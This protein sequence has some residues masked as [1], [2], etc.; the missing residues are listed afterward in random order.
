MIIVDAG[1]PRKEIIG[2][3]SELEVLTAEH[4]TP[5]MLLV[6]HEH[7]DHAKYVD[8]WT[9]YLSP[10]FMTIGTA[11]KLKVL[12][13]I[14]KPMEPLRIGDVTITAIRT[15][16]DAVDPVA[17]RIAHKGAAAVIATDLGELPQGFD[18]FCAGATDLLL[19]ANYHKRLLDSC[20]YAAPLKARIGSDQGHMDVEAVCE[21]LKEKLP[22]SVKRLWL[23]HLSAKCCH[24]SIVRRLASEALAGR[25]VE[26]EVI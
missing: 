18:L 2:R 4:H 11:N 5:D 9:K 20:D 15:Q 24:P 26:L 22:A 25:D 23:G 1:L 13:G 14:V 10:I 8:E 17:W 12:C 19:E 7:L 16:H 21:W 6:S 3:L